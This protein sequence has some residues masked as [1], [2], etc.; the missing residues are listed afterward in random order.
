MRRTRRLQVVGCCV[1]AV[2]AL[3]ACSSSSPKSGG[4]SATTAAGDTS[5]IPVAVQL[6][7]IP[8]SQNYAI[9]KGIADGSY[10]KVGLKV[11][12]KPGGIGVDP[13][14]VVG[15]GKADIGVSQQ[16]SLVI[17]EGKGLKLKVLG[18]EFG[19][20]ALGL[21]CR[22]D[23]GVTQLSEIAGKK[24]AVKAIAAQNFSVLLKAN[25]I[26]KSTVSV[27][28]VANDDSATIISG[29]VACVYA[30]LALNE[31]QII[32]TA[33]VD[34]R[35]FLDSDYGLANQD[36]VYFTTQEY[37]DK[38]KD[39]VLKPWIQATQQE[40]AG[41]IADPVTAANWVLDSHLV[42]GLN[43]DQ[44]LYQAK[45][46]VPFLLTDYDKTNGLLALEPELWV[47][48]AKRVLAAGSTSSLVDTAAMLDTTL[49]A[50][51]I[52]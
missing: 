52:S 48:S 43:K 5:L 10:A 27:V 33:G 40:W 2:A 51:S 21:I 18:A 29:K 17:A 47:N 19:H 12:F 11:S 26:D 25:N 31:P 3:A 16:D 36:N 35:I 1:A 37:Y 28:N 24:I 38:H 23:S 50:K 32:K 14:Q 30:G 9:P 41:F 13:I 46:M 44:E 34:N 22:T 20:S 6:G 45:A 4:S 7:F 8:N 39:D 42:D 15:A 49:A